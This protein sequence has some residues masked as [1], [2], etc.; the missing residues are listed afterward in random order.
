[1]ESNQMASLV[2]LRLPAPVT[3]KPGFAGYFALFV[4]VE[5]HYLS[6]LILFWAAQ[7]VAFC[8]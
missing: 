7:P 6:R 1:M 8:F 4:T 3:L 2:G 5:L